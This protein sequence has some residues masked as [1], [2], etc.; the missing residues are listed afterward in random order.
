MTGQQRSF[1]KSELAVDDDYAFIVRVSRRFILLSFCVSC[2]VA[3]SVGQIS[4]IFLIINPNNEF[5]KIY[6]DKLKVIG[7]TKE[8]YSRLS[9][10]GDVH[11]T[12]PDPV[13]QS[14]KRPPKTIYTS[15]NFNTAKSTTTHSR[16]IVTEVGDQLEDCVTENIGA[17]ISE[18]QE[19]RASTSNNTNGTKNNEEHLPAGQHLLIDIE[20]VDS[21][22]LNSEERLANAMLDLVKECGLTLLSYHCHGLH[23]SGVSCAGVLL[24]SHVSFH[25]W[26]EKNVIVIDLFTCGSN[27]LFPIVPLVENLFAIPT[28]M[29][30]KAGIDQGDKLI[31]PKP[32]MVWAHKYRGFNNVDS[33]PWA[34]SDMLRFP[35]GQMS[36]FKKEVCLDLVFMRLFCEH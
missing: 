8:D 7:V 4:R 35:V 34:D 18:H 31:S 20:H 24:E 19:C 16:W 6:H 25:T 22:F 28:M 5:L 27:S 23:P 11:F 21:T 2:L 10:S 32:K 12:L 14:G 17:D 30:S 1:G 15:K 9:S 26:P 33:S 13:L 3:Y 29:Q 36:D